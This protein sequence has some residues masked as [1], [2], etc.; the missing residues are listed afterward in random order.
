MKAER[1]SRFMILFL[2]ALFILSV[3]ANAEMKIARAVE[4]PK[5]Y[6][7]FEPG[8]DRMLFNYEELIGYLKKLD[9]ASPRL[10]MVEIGESPMGR[11]MY[12]AFISSEENIANLDNLRMINRRL[13]LDP[14]IP[15]S[16]REA[17]IDKGKVF[18]LATLS[19]H[20]GEV[21]PSQAAPLIAYKL[22]TT[23][24]PE[25]VEWLQDVVYM[26]V[27]N[28]NPDGMD[29][30]VA[31]Y[32]KYKGTKY[33]GCSMP[34]VYHK[35]VGHDN[36][37]DFVTLSQKDTKAIAHIYTQDWF[38]QVMIEKHQMGTTGVRY[39]VP[40]MH[41]PI[42]ENIE[43]SI[44]NW[45]KIFGSNMVTDMTK[46]GLAGVTQQYL[47]DDYWPGS[48]ETCI[49]M[50][51]IGMLTECASVKYATPV[52]VEPTELRVGG[53]G[54]SEYK[55]SINMVLPWPGGW[56]RLSDIVE[57]EVVSTL[58]IIKTSSLHREEILRLRND[59]CR[60][61][62]EKGKSQPPYYYI[63]PL[64]QHDI[65]ELVNLVSLLQEQ[66]VDVYRL[67][68]SVMVNGRSFNKGD[69]VVPLA[70]PFR[71]F[72]KEVMEKQI[73]PL[74][75][76]TPGGKIIK[77][78]DITS[79]SLPLHRAL[80]CLEINKRVGS[81]ESN[82]EK[83]ENDFRLTIS[84]P[85]NFW[86]ACFP[87]NN[88]E[89][90]KAAFNA[91]KSGLRVDRL[92]KS[93]SL[94]GRE[95]PEG[96]FI[97]YNKENNTKL[98]SLLEKMK[99]SPTY[100]NRKIEIMAE[101]LKMPRIALVETYFHDMDA[102]WTRFIFDSYGVSYKIVH[103]GD[104]EKTDF[105]KDFDIVI[106]PDAD[107]SVLMNGKPKYQNRYF[108]VDYPPEY[109]KG[110][111]KKGMERLMTFL[112]R[113]GIIIS[114]GQST[115][116][117][118]DKL[119]I[120]RG[121]DEKEEF[122]LPVRDISQEAAKSGLYCPGSLI[123]VVLKKDHPITLGMKREVGVFYRGR[124]LF[125]TSIPIFDMDR[126]VIGRFPERDILISGYCEKEEKIGNKAVLVWLRKGRGQLVLFGFNPQ[127]RASTQ[128]TYKLLF[129]SMFL[130][131]L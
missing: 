71:P 131:K 47:F 85:E 19:M 59:L 55:K 113:G 34:G 8:A 92:V 94:D 67:S 6:F 119:Q 40:P 28:H 38:P 65:S 11:K 129:N 72:I 14:D 42:S 97:I 108:I 18:F 130:K 93:V 26:M 20:S 62:F 1:L 91:L 22:V 117:F 112:D 57:Y 41:D 23:D 15:E 128:G 24:D 99:V 64:K 25:I 121:K 63:L 75:H 79:W 60:K 78:Y 35:Y 126:R 3:A 122:Q 37:R 124:P 80:E 29:M 120:M 2:T 32:R 61:E 69:I 66:G 49:W 45:T 89:S 123:R 77:P 44:L 116:L 70:Q 39:F 115:G 52:F 86:A 48:T 95:I 81:I 110:I 104:F 82:L 103:P 33:E 87:V 88:N 111:G 56:W 102:G 17:M 12:I 127:F 58:S 21:G 105:S 13:A 5:Q 84:I 114:W 118:L 98:K 68:G 83:I 10:K 30:V 4:T 90:F 53:K 107:K 76:Y 125:S 36:N 74:R 73:Y 106:F 109:T 9:N 101:P 27:P 96:S 31:H 100:L 43:A 50:N 16:E 54:L 7:G 46:K 51:V